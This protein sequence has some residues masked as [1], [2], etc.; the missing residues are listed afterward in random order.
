M[1]DMTR[2][3]SSGLVAL[4]TALGSVAIYASL[5]PA[6]AL[7]RGG[8]L[9]HRGETVVAADAQVAVLQRERAEGHDAFEPKRTYLG[10]LRRTGRR[11]LLAHTQHSPGTQ[12]AAQQFLVSGYSVTFYAWVQTRYTLTHSE[13]VVR[14]FDLKAGRRTL[15]EANAEPAQLQVRIGSASLV[16]LVVGGHGAAA[17]AVANPGPFRPYPAPACPPGIEVIARRGAIKLRAPLSHA[18]EQVDP[19]YPS[20]TVTGLAIHGRVVSWMFK[21]QR[22]NERF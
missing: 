12:L 10:C 22:Y 15:N 14:Q 3:V 18:C 13:D 1:G 5:L 6:G 9:P 4:A 8:C 2:C 16:E 11:M 19:L 20:P 21:G 7:A 17:W